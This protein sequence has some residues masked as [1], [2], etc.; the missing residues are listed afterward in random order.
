MKNRIIKLCLLLTVMAFMAGTVDAQVKKKP[1]RTATKR[2]ATSKTKK[3][4]TTNRSK[5]KA[6]AAIAPPVDTVKPA[7][8]E[9]KLDIP[10]IKKSLRNDYA[11]ERNLVKDRIP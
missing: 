1:S 9:A 2:G 5:N 11:M 3:K 7:P 4:G 6:T 8:P 10:P